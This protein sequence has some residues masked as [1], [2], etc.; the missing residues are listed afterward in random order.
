MSCPHLLPVPLAC[1]PDDV[2]CE[3][4]G[5]LKGYD[6]YINTEGYICLRRVEDD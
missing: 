2:I 5:G 1:S 4:C 3:D 6:R